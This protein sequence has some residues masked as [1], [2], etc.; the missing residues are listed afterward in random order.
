METEDLW[1]LSQEPTTCLYHEGEVSSPHYHVPFVQDL[2]TVTTIPAMFLKWAHH[3]RFPKLRYVCI[4]LSRVPTPSFF[5]FFCS[6]EQ[7]VFRS[8]NYKTPFYVK[9]SSVILVVRSYLEIFQL[10]CFEECSFDSPLI[11]FVKMIHILLYFGHHLS[12]VRLIYMSCW[13]IIYFR[14]HVI[15]CHY[16]LRSVTN[17]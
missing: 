3:S 10:D 7:Y 14:G 11:L 16:T 12:E 2:L 9:C 1:P 15:S 8:K 6:L 5:F 13:K 4:Y 17:S